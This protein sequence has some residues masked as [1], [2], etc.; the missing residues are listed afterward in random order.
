MNAPTISKQSRR[1]EVSRRA[2][3]LKAQHPDWTDN[4]CMAK[5]KGEYFSRQMK[6]VDKAV[7][8]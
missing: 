3:Q 8:A 2:A 6:S 5:A 1:P 7:R 4:E